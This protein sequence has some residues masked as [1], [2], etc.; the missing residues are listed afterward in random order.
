M[1]MTPHYKLEFFE[2]GCKTSWDDVFA[3]PSDETITVTITNNESVNYT[4]IEVPATASD[5]EDIQRQLAQVCT[6]PNMVFVT[7][8]GVFDSGE[9]YEEWKIS[10]ESYESFWARKRSALAPSTI[11]P[12]NAPRPRNHIGYSPK[13]V[14][15]KHV[16]GGYQQQ[17]VVY[18]SPK[19]YNPINTPQSRHVPIK[20]IQSVLRSFEGTVHG[21][22]E[23]TE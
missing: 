16:P 17:Q 9:E 23:V 15:A 4:P 5:I 18:G 13:R 19:F 1:K 22:M 7:G 21:R 6:N 11:P 10:N 3:A 14:I 20:V 2:D 8:L 12:L